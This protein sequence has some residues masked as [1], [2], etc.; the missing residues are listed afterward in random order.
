MTRYSTHAVAAAAVVLLS[1][2]CSSAGDD[3]KN[4]PSPEKNNPAQASSTGLEIRPGKDLLVH[5]GVSVAALDRE[6]LVVVKEVTVAEPIAP[7]RL[8]GTDGHSRVF[9]GAFRYALLGADGIS[10]SGVDG[11]IKVADLTAAGTEK[12]LLSLSRE[13]LS[14]A[15]ATGTVSGVQFSAQS[16]EPE[17]WFQTVGADSPNGTSWSSSTADKYTISSLW[18]VN[19]KDWQA[20]NLSVKNREI[21][22]EV[23]QYW[24]SK[25]CQTAFSQGPGQEGFTP[26]SCWLV[27]ATGTPVASGSSSARTVQGSVS[28]GWTNP[29][30]GADSEKITFSYLKGSDGKPA[31]PVSVSGAGGNAASTLDGTSGIIDSG[32]AAQGV[33]KTW[34]FV[35]AGTKLKLTELPT[36][37]PTTDSETETLLWA[38]P[39]GY[40]VAKVGSGD[41]STGWTMNAEGEW[42][43]VGAWQAD[44][45]D[46]EI[47][48]TA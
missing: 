17:L 39:D 25:K 19:V 33:R 40:A 34:K 1:A 3:S 30:K 11:S 8:A 48:P 13:Q 31:S 42:Q 9:D 43:R 41:N 46:A 23:Q 32:A 24:K 10:S 5:Q 26:W 21:P 35:T 20:G 27:D 15:G 47:E 4:G 22:A 37:L 29:A 6:S 38:F 7:G 12:A 18:S 2:G 36:A 44:L 45:D 14:A 28:T 16:G